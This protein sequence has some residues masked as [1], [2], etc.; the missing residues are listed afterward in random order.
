MEKMQENKCRYFCDLAKYFKQMQKQCG[1][2]C[3]WQN[4]SD[5]SRTTNS[6]IPIFE[7][8]APIIYWP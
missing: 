4:K 8:E 1:G 7:I 2:F 5:K 6:S 3:S